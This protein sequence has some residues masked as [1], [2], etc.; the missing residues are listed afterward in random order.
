MFSPITV[1][2]CEIIIYTNNAGKSRTYK[3]M[4]G[5]KGVM[6]KTVFKDPKAR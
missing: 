4:L 1:K 2:K 3:L 6:L 5:S